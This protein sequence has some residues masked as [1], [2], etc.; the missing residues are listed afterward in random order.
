MVDRFQAVQTVEE[1][2]RDGPIA[3]NVL[4]PSRT[5]WRVAWFGETKEEARG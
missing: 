5:M 1:E 2:I 3:D 4:V